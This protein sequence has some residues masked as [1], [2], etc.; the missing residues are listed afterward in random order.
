MWNIHRPFIA[1][2]AKY[3]FYN[4]LHYFSC[5]S[6][7]LSENEAN[8]LLYCR[9]RTCNIGISCFCICSRG[10]QKVLVFCC[11]SSRIGK[12]PLPLCAFKW[13]RTMAIDYVHFCFLHGCNF[14]YSSRKVVHEKSRVSVFYFTIIDF[15]PINVKANIH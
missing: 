12:R 14:H 7:L 1:I 9:Q 15:H 10:L 3:W 5:H 4:N 6:F 11:F 8:I 13:L 2:Q